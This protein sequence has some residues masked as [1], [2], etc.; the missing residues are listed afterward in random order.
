MGKM[1]IKHC[2]KERQ[3]CNQVL[4]IRSP[5]VTADRFLL[6]RFS[7]KKMSMPNQEVVEKTKK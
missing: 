1:V 2:Q 5:A 3:D 7:H 6:N 4:H